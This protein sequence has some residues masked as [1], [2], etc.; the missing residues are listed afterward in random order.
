MTS[1]DTPLTSLLRVADVDRRRT[2]DAL[3]Q[4]YVAGRLTAHELGERITRA[5]AAQTHGELALLLRDLPSRDE[6]AGAVAAPSTGGLGH[7]LSHAAQH[8]ARRALAP[9]VASYV[10]V[11]TLLLAIWLLTTPGG[12]FWPIWPMLG[13]GFGLAKHAIIA[14]YVV[15]SGQRCA[16]RSHRQRTSPAL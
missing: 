16:T 2:V 6:P 14:T 13:W 12:Y 9:H 10:A 1:L 3:K 5:L 4:H 11:M 7:A 8:P 15:G